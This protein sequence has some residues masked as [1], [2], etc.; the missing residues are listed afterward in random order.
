MVESRIQLWTDETQAEFAILLKNSHY[1]IKTNEKTEFTKMIDESALMQGYWPHVLQFLSFL[2]SGFSSCQS[3]LNGINDQYPI[4]T[5]VQIT[6]GI[7]FT[8]T[9]IFK[10][11]NGFRFSTPWIIPACRHLF[12][13]QLA[14][15]GLYIFS[16]KGVDE[17]ILRRRS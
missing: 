11:A 1:V 15:G 4:V 16:V 2:Y 7:K 8:H 13:G 3:A 10:R 5:I 9:F 17:S 6:G 12:T 14:E